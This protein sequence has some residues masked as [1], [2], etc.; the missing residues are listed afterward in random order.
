MNSHPKF[1][2]MCILLR[3]FCTEKVEYVLETKSQTTIIIPRTEFIQFMYRL[4][5]LVIELFEK[6]NELGPNILRYVKNSLLT[7]LHLNQ[8]F[9]QILKSSNGENNSELK[10]EDCKFI[11]ERCVLIYMK[12]HQ[13]TW[14]SVNNYIPK[15]GIA[16]L[17]E[18]LKQ[19]D[20]AKEYN[21]NEGMISDILKAKNHWLAVDFDSYQAGLRSEK[22]MP[23]PI[24]EEALTLWVENALQAGFI[25][26]DGILSNKALEFAFLCKED[27]FKESNG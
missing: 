14:R 5:S 16:S 11:Y 22:K 1:S 7:N 13:K 17:R 15:K 23:F 10:N 4:E 12:S 24:I 9:I 27:K 8:T 3:S 19:K 21:V 6:Y 20:L 26:S 18:S 25:I 2:V